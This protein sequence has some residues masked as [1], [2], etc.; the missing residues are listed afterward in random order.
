[1]HGQV[2]LAVIAAIEDVGDCF[3]GNTRPE[4]MHADFRAGFCFDWL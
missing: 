3:D 1:M 4:I 2:V